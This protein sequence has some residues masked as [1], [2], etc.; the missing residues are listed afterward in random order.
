[1][2]RI[3]LATVAALSIA[4]TL[5]PAQADTFSPRGYWDTIWKGK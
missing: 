3:I 5:A 2:K 1:M 4:A